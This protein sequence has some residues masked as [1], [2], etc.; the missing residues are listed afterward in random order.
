M[1]AKMKINPLMLIMTGMFAITCPHSQAGKGSFDL[2]A[3]KVNMHL[4]L[5]ETNSTDYLRSAPQDNATMS[6]W[7][8]EASK[9]MWNATEGNMR[10]GT[11][12]VY[13]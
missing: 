3:K 1:K 13:N 5:T 7:F 4:Y 2:P 12:Y 10:I 11:I 9:K 8:N 6:Y